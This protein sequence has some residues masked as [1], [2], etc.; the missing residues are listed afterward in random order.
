MKRNY[1]LLVLFLFSSVSILAQ[2]PEKMSYQLV[3]RGAS[4]T[5]LTNQQVGIQISIL[6]TTITGSAVYTETQTAT[7]NINGLVSLEIGSGTSSDDF[8]TIDWSA[9]PFFIKTATDASGG[10][11][12][13]IIGT[14]Q[15]MSV[16]F[17]LYAKTS[18]SSTP[19]PQG[20]QGTQGI[21]GETGTAGTDG[22]NGI[23]GIQGAT[24]AVG[25]DGAAGT[26]GTQ[27]TQ[28][29]TGAAGADGATGAAGTNGTNG[30]NGTQGT[31]GATGA[32]GADGTNG[33]QGTQGA[34]GADG[35][36]GTNGVQGSTGL[37]GAQGAAGADG[38]GIAQTLLISGDT[39]F[40]S[41]GNY[42]I[43]PGLSLIN[44]L[45]V[46][47]CNDPAAFNYDA[48][49]N[50]DDGSCIAVVNGCMDPTAFNYDASANIDDGSCIAVVN[51]CM[52]STAFN[53]DASAN[54]DD[55]SCIAV[56]N[57]C[58][59]PTAFNYNALANTDD[60]SC[61]AVVNGCTDST[62]TNY[63][64]AANTDDGSCTYPLAIGDTHQGGIVFYL[65]GSGGGL[66]AAPTDQ[67][68][69]AEWGCHGTAIP[70]ADGTAIGTGAQN[71]IDIVNANCS[72]NTAGNSIAANICANLTLGG[73][74]DWFLPSKDEL[75]QMHL[76]IG[77]GDSLG[78]GNVGG[79][80]TYN[81]WSSSEYNS[82]VAW[83]QF[84]FSKGSTYN[85]RAVRALSAP[86]LGC[87]DPLY[88]EYDALANTDDGTCTTL[89]VNGC[90]DSTAFN[91][92]ALANTD[93]GSC[94]AVVNGCTDSTAFNYDSS[95]NTDDGS[96][97]AVVNG[98]TDSTATNY[99]A[100][101]NTDDGSCTYPLAIGDTYG[102]GIVFY[103]DGNGGGLIAAPT[104]QSTGAQWGCYGT[105][106]SG[107][108]GTAIGTG[109]QNT[110]DIINASC[111]SNN[112]S[113]TAA[114]ICANLTLGGY[115]DWFLPSK[116]ELNLMFFNIGKGNTLGLGNIGG[117]T[118]N[119]YWSSSEYNNIYAW[120]QQFGGGYPSGAN[121]V[122]PTPSV[123]AFRAF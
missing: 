94:I 24:G 69:G 57:G 3:L 112:G 80:V 81:Y 18:G 41:S 119:Y 59:D 7:T 96:C 113:P 33:T 79:F 84:G 47:G 63:N 100:A 86:I 51:G 36:D 91:Y 123:R 60:G 14:S 34:T 108:D 5:L 46:E 76:N 19:G 8:S 52:D 106:I 66:I 64:A 6:Q 111:T 2:T 93:D 31:Q 11:N 72:P 53:Y 29:A 50:T 116:D 26:N 54:T 56:V 74:S 40:I 58:M 73:Y 110:L 16:P 55:G 4:N 78:L 101:A 107:A 65:D 85:V 48:S 39:L 87:T 43:I 70:G 71:T 28:G 122:F 30:T 1:T 104:D 98:C 115:S 83:G 20:A 89:V 37:A 75:N 92:N 35:A 99:N 82:N 12:Y 9:G 38:I 25:A 77:Q 118:T 88:T 97:I 45:I 22:T 17:A 44:S 120:L 61:I 15:L 23:Q 27:G 49:A 67:S 114:D 121:K 13:S 103:L 42:I 90:T 32:A 95:A 21:Q 68:T 109:A 105:S 10:S 62:A 102:G 117:F